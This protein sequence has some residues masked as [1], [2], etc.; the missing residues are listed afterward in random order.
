LGRLYFSLQYDTCTEALSV[1][2]K[3]IRNLPKHT[4][5]AGITNK[6]YVKS[7]VHRVKRVH[8]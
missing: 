4:K 5:E 3:R 7:V 8:F 2:V 1:F 6:S